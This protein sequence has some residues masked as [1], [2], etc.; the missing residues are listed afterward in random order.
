MCSGC[1]FQTVPCPAGQ[2][3]ISI[4]GGATQ[5]EDAHHAY[6]L[7]KLLS[8]S[9]GFGTWFEAL[10][11]LALVQGRAT[12]RA[13]LPRL[14]VCSSHAVVSEHSCEARSRVGQAGSI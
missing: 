6:D 5:N 8:L 4:E 7:D 14:V 11:A 2:G 9:I 1:L 3:R 10:D 12:Q 13:E